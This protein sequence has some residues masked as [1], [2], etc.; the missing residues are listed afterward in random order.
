MI[1]LRE[2]ASSK[3]EKPNNS[4]EIIKKYF[5]AVGRLTKQKNFNYL[6]NEFHFFCKKI[7]TIIF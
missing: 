2:F 5:I 1:N 4:I 3:F 6:I 7:M